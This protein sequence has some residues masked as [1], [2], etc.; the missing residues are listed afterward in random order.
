MERNTS[1]L[2]SSNRWS[3]TEYDYDFKTSDFVPFKGWKKYK[4]RISFPIEMDIYDGYELGVYLA[5]SAILGIY[6][7]ALIG[8]PACFGIYGAVKGIESLVN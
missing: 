4:E 3:G 5:S 7:L 8:I 1:D 6:N 2:D